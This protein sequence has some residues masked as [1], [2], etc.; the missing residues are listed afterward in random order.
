M[1]DEKA[2]SYRLSPQQELVWTMRPDGPTDAGQLI[3]GLEGPVDVDRLRSVFALLIDRHEILRTTYTRQAGMKTPLQVVRDTV[4]LDW[5]LI[6]LSRLDPASLQARMGEVA[7]TERGRSWNYENG[8]LISARCLAMAPDRLNLVVTAAAPCVDAGALAAIAAELEPHYAGRATDEQPLQYAD[9]SEWQNQLAVAD[10]EEAAAGRQFWTEAAADAA[11]I[12]PFMRRVAPAATETVPVTLPVET[13]GLESVADAHGTSLASLIF[14]AWV[15]VLWKLNDG[16]EVVVASLSARRLH[17]ELETA[18]GAFSRPLPVRPSL[19]GELTAGDLAAQLARSQELAERW[20]D[21]AP[22]DAEVSGAGFVEVPRIEPIEDEGVTMSCLGIAPPAVFPIA[23]ESDGTACVLR[24]EPSALDRPSAERVA[25]HVECV[26]VSIASSPERTLAEIGLLDDVDLQR[27]TVEV[28]DTATAF[29]QTPIHELIAQAA[30]SAPTKD[31][32]VDEAGTLSYATL[33]ARSN[34]VANRLRRAGVGPDSVVGLCADRSIEMIVGL[35]G[36]L[37]AGGAYLPLNF[38]HPP[39]R[40]AHQLRET[41]APVLVTQESLLERVPE[42]EGEVVCLDRDRESLDGEPTTAPEVA[43]SPDNL[44]YVIYT[45]GSTGTPKGVGV[46]HANLANYVHAISARL[47]AG[48]AAL[49]FGM[50]T[51][52]S[53]DLGNTAV[54]P[55][56]CTGGTL[57]LVSPGA[58]ADA[59]A[60]AEYLRA[61]PVDVLK[62]TPSHLNALLVGVDGADVLPERWL[63]FGGEALSWDIVARVRELGSCRILNHYGPTETTV[64]SCTFVIEESEESPQT[65]TAPIGSPLANTRCYV[66]DEAGRCVPE[67]VV[68]ELH[69]AGAGVASGYVGRPD[70]TEER[71]LPDQFSGQGRMY[72]TGDL[73]RRL[74]KGDIE[75]MGRRDDQVK[76]R[77][78]RVEPAEI[79][80]ALRSHEHVDEA[81]VVAP[82]DA[83]GEH[84]LIAYVVAPNVATDE[85]RRHLADWIPE[86]MIPSVFVPI[87][88]VPRT[89]SGKIDR[90]SLPSPESVSAPS[91]GPVHT[92]PRTPVEQAIAAL[93]ADVLGVEKVG[94]DDDFFALGGHSLLATQIV[95]QLRSDFAVNLPLHALFTFPT[96]ATLSQQVVE[97]MGES[98]DTDTQGLIAELEGLSDE[99]VARLLQEGEEAGSS[100]Q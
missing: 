41:E 32:V 28:N 1:Q 21:F 49:A 82:I 75:F 39:A 16:D 72:A 24:Y 83:R 58:A 30:A 76:I 50:M 78:F 46:T 95:A 81:V 62:I 60:A 31:A 7:A 51:A 88:A 5:E 19:S 56:L 66:L 22:A 4:P 38:E 43:V 96:V 94:V 100:L 86:F 3:V 79:E 57:V 89:A 10:D 23:L 73:V 84:R 69:I 48:E 27:L 63:V 45:S 47:G 74:P 77:G 6:D 42:F 8:P 33:E 98:P 61:H 37:K 34:Q 71:F 25:R 97:L 13:S 52:I 91:T 67:G 11:T 9:F 53:T 70:L 85:L 18:V 87:D 44:A 36:I 20:Q 99:E 35:L 40:L 54:F 93:W 59:A 14:A 17:H 68:G 12:V 55:A 29:P 2:I 65:A 92:A 90:L 64:G 15:T 80:A 26:L